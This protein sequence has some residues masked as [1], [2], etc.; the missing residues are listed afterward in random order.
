M[1]YISSTYLNAVPLSEEEAAWDKV[2]F[3]IKVKST[4][5]LIDVPANTSIVKILREHGIEVETACEDGYCGTCITR[6]LE[7]TAHRGARK[8]L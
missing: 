5:E 4:G 6:Y 8:I 1:P 7:G 3:K 2:P